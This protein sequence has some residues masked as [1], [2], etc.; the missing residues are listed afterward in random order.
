MLVT[1]KHCVLAY[2][3]GL[4]SACVLALW[5]GPDALI[6]LGFKLHAAQQTYAYDGRPVL[7][8][9][10]AQ[11]VAELAKPTKGSKR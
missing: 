4:I 5:A 2:S 3:G 6:Q 7:A 11:M 10:E 1:W 9:D 8:V